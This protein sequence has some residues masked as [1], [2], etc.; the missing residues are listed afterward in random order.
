[1]QLEAS[2]DFVQGARKFWT[3]RER[4]CTSKLRL[5]EYADAVVRDVNRCSLLVKTTATDA[6]A[7][8]ELLPSISVAGVCRSKL[9]R[10]HEHEKQTNVMRAHINF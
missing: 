2:L 5:Y 10:H 8:V 3:C 9:N 1:M 4:A 7:N 6:A